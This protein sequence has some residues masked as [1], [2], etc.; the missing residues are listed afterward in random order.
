VGFSVSGKVAPEKLYPAPLIAAVLIVSAPFP[1]ELKVNVCVVAVFTATLPNDRL[2]A[3]TLSVPT[4]AF[5]VSVKLC[6][7]LVVDAVS[8][9]VCA[10]ATAV[11]V[12]VKPALFAPPAIWTDGG[13]VT[14]ALLLARFTLIPP[15][16]AFPL[17]VTVHASV[18]APVSEFAVQLSDCTVGRIAMVPVPLNATVSVP[19][20]VALLEMVRLPDWAPAAVG[21]NLTLTTAD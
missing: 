8:T 4:D 1:V 18:A 16:G 21:L 7:L 11:A 3:L 5:S 10:V 2:D 19:P 15:V 20:V 6:E 14:A 9:A 13:R 17:T 12:A